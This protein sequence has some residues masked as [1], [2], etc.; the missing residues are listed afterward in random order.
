MYVYTPALD[1]TASTVFITPET[2]L[3]VHLTGA[4]K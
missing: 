1:A 4:V 3:L 2:G